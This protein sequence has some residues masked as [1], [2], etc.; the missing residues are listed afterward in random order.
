MIGWLHGTVVE[1][2]KP[3]LCLINVNG[4][5][6]E[7]NVPASQPKVQGE[8]VTFFV[9]TQ[10]RE[11]AITLFGFTTPAER[12]LF[13]KLTQV[14]G[15]GAKVAMALLSIGPSETLVQAIYQGDE[16]YLTQGEGIGPK[17]A[18]RLLNELK[19]KSLET[20]TALPG[21]SITPLRENLPKGGYAEKQMAL[22]ALLNLGMNDREARLAIE[23]VYVEADG[24]TL[25]VE[26]VVRLSLKKL[27]A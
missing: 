6:Y 27:S 20:S 1:M 2:T 19:D 18:K 7:V 12:E 16:R 15:V 10:V 9:H 21:A 25:Q 13:L 4:V 14:P 3:T 24:A 22:S 17:L 8:V 11:D 26:E 5:G 23:Q